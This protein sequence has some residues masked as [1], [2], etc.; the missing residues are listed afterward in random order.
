VVRARHDGALAAE[1]VVVPPSMLLYGFLIEQA[2]LRAALLL[3]LGNVALGAY[4]ILNRPARD[5]DGES[6]HEPPQLLAV[7]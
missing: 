6:L 4:A 2:G 1:M 3:L 7:R 5:L